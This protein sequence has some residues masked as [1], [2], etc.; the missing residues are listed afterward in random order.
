M[1]III[2][3]LA[4]L[5]SLS[6]FSNEMSE[7]LVSKA[8]SICVY[9][10]DDGIKTVLLK[11]YTSYNNAC[12]KKFCELS[13]KKQITYHAIVAGEDVKHPKDVNW[14]EFSYTCY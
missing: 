4:L 8:V 13:G 6:A 2:L 12:S 7:E 9:V 5:S 3:V 10:D 1:K 11:D 14:G